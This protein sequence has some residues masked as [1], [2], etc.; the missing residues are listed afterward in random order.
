MREGCGLPPTF[1]LDRSRIMNGT[2][3]CG[4]CSC[5]SIRTAGRPPDGSSIGSSKRSKRNRSDE[6]SARPASNG[7]GNCR[8]KWRGQDDILFFPSAYS[9]A[10]RHLLPIRSDGHSLHNGRSLYSKPCS[11]IPRAINRLFL[12]KHVK[13]ATVRSCASSGSQIRTSPNSL[14]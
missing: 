13:R 14:W 11:P 4:E 8:I 9:R 7:C 12:R 5:V 10:P 3:T 2:R 6:P 1:S